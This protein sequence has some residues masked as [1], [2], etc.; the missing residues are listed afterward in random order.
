MRD[1]RERTFDFGLRIIRISKQVPNSK[2]NIVL[3]RQLLRAGTSIGANVEEA[4]AAYTRQEFSYKMS[5]ALKE[6]RETQ[7]WLRL[8]K[9]SNIVQSDHLDAL[10]SEAE[11]LKKIL[12]SIV[13]KTRRPLK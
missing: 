10:I 4:E 1:L 7:Y 11:E 9:E 3:V 13:A 12:G 2:E 6:A 5:I 8:V